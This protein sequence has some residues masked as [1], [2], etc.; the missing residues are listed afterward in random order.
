MWVL[1]SQLRSLCR[2]RQ[3]SETLGQAVQLPGTRKVSGG[4]PGRCLVGQR[5]QR[6]R[7]VA[8]HVIAPDAVYTFKHS[9]VQDVAYQSLLKFRREQLHAR[10]ARALEGRF[11]ET[12]ATRPEL[13]AQHY[14]AAGLHD[15]AVDYWH[16]AGQRASERSANLEAIAHLTRGLE[17]ARKFSDPMQSARQEQKRLVALGEPL[18]GAKGVGASEVGITYT[19]ALELCR[20]G[21]IRAICSRRCGDRGT[22]TTAKAPCRPP[23][24]W[25]IIFCA[26]PSDTEIRCC[27]WRPIR[28]SAI[29]CIIWGNSP[30]R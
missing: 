6:C 10:I 1:S 24:I 22:S 12:A 5:G 15:Q 17:L 8:R 2:L 16:Q 19:R 23:A 30:P 9:L 21:A 3:R 18:A 29:R 27:S 4:R 14:T 20:Q 13:L 7:A 26:W 25:A 11:P 28:R